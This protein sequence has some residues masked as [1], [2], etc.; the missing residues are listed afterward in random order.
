LYDVV[1]TVQTWRDGQ[2]FVDRRWEQT[3]ERDLT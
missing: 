3:I 2:P 1:L